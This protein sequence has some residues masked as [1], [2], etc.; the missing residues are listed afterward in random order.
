MRLGEWIKKYRETNNMSLQDMAD[1]CG[2]SKSYVHMLEKGVNPTTNRVVSPTVMTLQ[3]IANATGQDVDSFLK[4]IDD[5]QPVTVKPSE[6]E[7]DAD[8]KEFLQKYRKLNVPNKQSLMNVMS[9][10]LA[11]QSIALPGAATMV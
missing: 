5:D 7:I 9:A 10:F 4:N 11:Q 8:E 3:K 6:F 1:M 2:F